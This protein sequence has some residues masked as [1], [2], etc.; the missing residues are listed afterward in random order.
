MDRN[1][2]VTEVRMLE[3]AF[4]ESVAR[5]RL[6][7]VVSA[8]FATCALLLASL[9]LYGLLASLSPNATNEIGIRMA[10]GARA[11]EVLRLVLAHGLRLV[12]W[13]AAV[14]LTAAFALS[15]FSKALLFAVTAHIP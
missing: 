11:P 15:D 1:L 4:G 8:G 6:N 14:G 13:G 5:E 12:G 2:P 7:A 10:L 9:G 3:D